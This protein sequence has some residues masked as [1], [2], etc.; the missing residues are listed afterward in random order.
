MRPT[1]RIF[2]K[3]SDHATK[4][5]ALGR[6]CALL[7]DDNHRVH[8]AIPIANRRSDSM[9]PTRLVA[10]ALTL[11]ALSSGAAL[12]QTY[13]TPDGCSYTRAQAPGYPATW[14]LIINPERVGLPT[15]TARCAAML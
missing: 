11:T 4:I 8:S 2:E 6:S 14:H 7:T 15:P 5:P 13:T 10:T 1:N 9:K 3:S 12:A